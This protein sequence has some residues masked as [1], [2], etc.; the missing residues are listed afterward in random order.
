MVRKPFVRW[1]T[2]PAVAVAVFVGWV[3][4][5]SVQAQVQRP[6]SDPVPRAQA[7]Q[8]TDT[9]RQTF[10]TPGESKPIVI[11]A[12]EIITWVENGQRVLVLRGQVLVQQNAVQTRF[13]Q[14]VAWLDVDYYKRTGGIQHMELYGEG[15][16]AVDNA[17]E[18]KKAD[19]IDLNLYTRG[20]LKLNS[21]AKPVSVLKEAPASDPLVRRAQAERTPATPKAPATPPAPTPRTTPAAPVPSAPAPVQSAPAPVSPAPSP[22]A[23]GPS[24]PVP[25]PLP[26]ALAPMQPPMPAP[27]PPTIQQTA[28]QPPEVP[29]PAPPPPVVAP[30]V[31]V[32]PA[33]PPAAGGGPPVPGVPL[34]PLPPGAKPP[35]A[36][37]SPPRQFSVR[38]RNSNNFDLWSPPRQPGETGLHAYVITGGLILNISNPGGGDML[39]IEADRLVIWTNKDLNDPKQLTNAN[40]LAT[41]A[42][43]ESHF[44]FYLAGN[45]ELRQTVGKDSHTLRAD[46]LY[47][48]T[49]RNVAVA[50]KAQLEFKPPIVTDNIVIRSDEMYQHALSQYEVVHAEIFSS[51]LPSDPGLKVVVHQATI[52][53]QPVPKFGTFGNR[54]FNRTTGE[55]VEAKQTI[56]KGQDVYFELENVPFFYSPYLSGDAREPLG[57]VEDIS[58]GYNKPYGFQFGTTLNLYDLFGIQ[59]FENTKWRGTVDYLTARGPALGTTFDYSPKEIFGVH[60]VSDGTFTSWGIYDDGYDVLAAPR[61]GDPPVPDERGR[62]RWTQG[63]YELPN[64]FT[65]QSQVAAVSDRNFLEQYFQNEWLSGPNQST[66]LYVKQSPEHENWAWY[67][68]VEPRLGRE[69]ITE[70]ESLPRF[71]GMIIGQSFFDLLSYN[72]RGSAGYY[73]LRTSND[74]LPP[75]SPTDQY[76]R[77]TRFDLMQELSLPFTTGPV[78][79]DPYVTAD[80]TQYSQDLNNQEVGRVWVGGGLRA[81]M[82]LTRLYPDVQSELWNLNGLNHKIVLSANY[83]YAHSDEPYTKFAQIDRLNDDETDQTLRDLRP[84]LPTL[85]PGALGTTLATSKIFDP[86]LY[87]I[88]TLVDS[89]IDTRDSID[90]LQMDVRQRLQTKRGYPGAEHI[91]DWMTLDLSAS[92]FPN[93]GRDNFNEHW[94]F[95]QYDYVWNVGD[96]TTVTSSGWVDPIDTGARTWA[97][98]LF[99]NRPDR[100][101]FYLGFRLIDPVESRALT[102]AVTYIFSTKYSMTASATYDFGLALSE[103]NSLVFTRVGTDL[104]I[105]AGITYNAFTNSI[106][107]V[108]EIVP[109]LVPANRRV[110]PITA[111]GAGGTVGARD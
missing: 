84:Q 22:P 26:P 58:F 99:L 64:G 20:E 102:A 56:F 69:W 17:T 2:E 100:T 60:T 80:F 86:Q 38:P 74:G 70:G 83:F 37:E 96:R 14:G 32:P 34:P 42:G 94:A 59:P 11:D 53:D 92:Y 61:V 75:V 105:S 98:G 67:G 101:N 25:A 108:V 39:D 29:P 27:V 55:Q 87:A 28:F 77:T 81:S 91:E 36:V 95:L 16:A 30:T 104:Q 35:A 78:R 89:A 21:H 3:C 62:L 1:L 15:E 109:N 48:D 51:K 79:L 97:L 65:V 103:S 47:Y 71:D 88:R 82:P 54:V 76:D 111:V 43:G 85:Y 19:R 73:Q 7:L 107:A 90:V 110:G 31:P 50:L 23:F 40:G 63:F 52:I 8:S 10:N 41:E 106:G 12:D 45:V 4:I 6:P 44:E 68:L 93:A 49:T 66:W 9:F 33:V 18:V 57:P 13:Q 24:A 72:A 5:P 46:E